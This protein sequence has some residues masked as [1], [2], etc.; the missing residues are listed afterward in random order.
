[1]LTRVCLF[2]KG[3]HVSLPPIVE[4]LLISTKYILALVGQFI[5]F[6]IGMLLPGISP[7]IS[8][9]LI[10]HALVYIQNSIKSTFIDSHLCIGLCTRQKFLKFDSEL[11]SAWLGNML[12]SLTLAYWT[13]ISIHYKV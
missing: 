10:I 1:M 2:S 9:Y 8:C 3:R 6:S 4:L 5:C 7:V 11:H 12:A 13:M